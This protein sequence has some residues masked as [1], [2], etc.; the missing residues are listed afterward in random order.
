MFQPTL[1]WDNVFEGAMQT[2]GKHRGVLAARGPACVGDRQS[3]SGAIG[4]VLRGRSGM[5]DQGKQSK[6]PMARLGGLAGPRASKHAS[7]QG[8]DQ[9]L[10]ESH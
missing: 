7:K 9:N 2:R 10:A 5:A 8:N 6:K 3:L 1:R 4:G